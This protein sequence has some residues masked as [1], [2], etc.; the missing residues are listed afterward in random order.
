MNVFIVYAHPEPSSFN[1]ALLD[2]VLYPIRRGILEF[3]GFD[4]AAPF[5]TY[6]PQRMSAAERRATLDQFTRRL[7]VM[8]GA[9]PAHVHSS[10]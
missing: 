9:R 4:V 1:A 7:N 6:A 3:T 5:V 10:Q 2:T 8:T